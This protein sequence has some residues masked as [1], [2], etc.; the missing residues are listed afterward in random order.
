MAQY[1]ML[2]ADAGGSKVDW[3]LI[4][5]SD[6]ITQFVTEGIQPYFQ[7]EQDI[8]QILNKSTLKGHESEPNQVYYYGAGCGANEQARKM[9]QV[10]KQFFHSSGVEVNSDMLGSARAACGHSAGI[11]CILGT[12]SNACF[13]DGV[14]IGAS[15]PSLGFWLGD[16]GSG[17]HIGKC[18]LQRYLKNQLPVDLTSSFEK[19]FKRTR[20]DWMRIVYELPKPNTEIARI[21]K[22]AYDHQ[23]HPMIA[24]LVMDCFDQFLSTSV[25]PLILLS[26]TNTL[27]FTGSIAF[28]FNGFLRKAVENRHWRIGHIL[29]HPIAGIALYHHTQP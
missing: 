26:G 24:Q 2:I 13:F 19:R 4:D 25:A 18:L 7:S 28:Y 16:E 10:L 6:S 14:D 20:P 27:H 22:W 11:A 3:R 9:L 1:P 23:T 15:A 21:A 12:G 5:I 17:A 29:E 8:L